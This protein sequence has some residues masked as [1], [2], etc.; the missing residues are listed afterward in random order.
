MNNQAQT[1]IIYAVVLLLSI[2][3]TIFITIATILRIRLKKQRKC[4]T[5]KVKAVVTEMKRLTASSNYST[6]TTAWFPVYKYYI[7]KGQYIEVQSNFGQDKQI[8][9]DL[10]EVD[11]FYNPD[12]CTEYYVPAENV[13]YMQTVMFIVGGIL[14]VCGILVLVGYFVAFTSMK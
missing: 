3:G 2:M 4:C 13:G 6:P 11:L 10:Q 5:R 1:I 7:G 12:N 14:T 8:F 9:H